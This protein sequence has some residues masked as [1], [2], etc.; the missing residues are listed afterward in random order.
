MP[1]PQGSRP[2]RYRRTAL[3][4][5]AVFVYVTLIR[6]IEWS[7]FVLETK[8]E[9]ALSTETG[10]GKHSPIAVKVDLSANRNNLESAVCLCVAIVVAWLHVREFHTESELGI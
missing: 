9:Q 4:N 10:F 8:L 2:K 7:E 3:R 6:E 5:A 1:G